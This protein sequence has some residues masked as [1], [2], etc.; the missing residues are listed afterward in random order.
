MRVAALT[1]EEQ[2][3]IRDLREQRKRYYDAGTKIGDLMRALAQKYF[4]VPLH[5]FYHDKLAVDQAG[6]YIILE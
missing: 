4:S 1:L 5:P 6:K 3:Q 2:D